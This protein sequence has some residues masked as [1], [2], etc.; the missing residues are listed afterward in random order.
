[1][2]SSR[3]GLKELNENKN[4]KSHHGKGYQTYHDLLNQL[5]P[6]RSRLGHHCHLV[7]NAHLCLWQEAHV[8]MDKGCQKGTCVMVSL[9]QIHDICDQRQTYGI[10][11]LDRMTDQGGMRPNLVVQV[12]VID[13][14][15]SLREGDPH[16]V[17]AQGRPD[18]GQREMFR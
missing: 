12:E 5:T 6:C 16:P 1:M 15:S 10:I 14:H 8:S 4:G 7:M 9:D 3:C 18:L 17:L 13:R 11:S 2:I